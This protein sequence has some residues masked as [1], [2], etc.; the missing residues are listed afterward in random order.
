MGHTH[1]EEGDEEGGAEEGGGEAGAGVEV[2]CH[3]WRIGGL[4]VGLWVSHC[5]ELLGGRKLLALSR[6]VSGASLGD[7][8]L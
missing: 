1:D 7:G 3:W 4:F 2:G 8:Y 5:V 6:G